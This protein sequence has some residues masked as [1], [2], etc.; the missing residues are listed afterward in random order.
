MTAFM[1]A[2]AALATMLLA[3]VLAAFGACWVAP[4]PAFADG[5]GEVALGIVVKGAQE[6]TAQGGSVE[7]AVKLAAKDAPVAV[8][9]AVDLL[10][11][12]KARPVHRISFVGYYCDEEGNVVLNDDGSQKKET[13]EVQDVVEGGRVSV[14]TNLARTDERGTEYWV[15]GWYSYDALGKPYQIDV[16]TY[17][18]AAGATIFCYWKQGYAVKLDPNNGQ[19]ASTGAA[20]F[21]GTVEKAYVSVERDLAF[22]QE[23]PMGDPDGFT[24]PAFPAATRAGYVFKGWYWADPSGVHDHHGRAE[25]DEATGVVADADDAKGYDFFRE[26]CADAVPT[27]Y[28]KWE[29]APLVKVQLEEARGAQ[30]DEWIDL[31]FWPGRGYSLQRPVADKEIEPG[32]VIGRDDVPEEG[33]DVT[34]GLNIAYNPAPRYSTQVFSGWGYEVQ[35]DAGALVPIELV[36][37]HKAEGQDGFTYTLGPLAF[38]YVNSKLQWTGPAADDNDPSAPAGQKVATWTPLFDFAHIS[39]TAPFEVVFQ[40]KGD[41]WATDATDVDAYTADELDRKSGW[42]WVESI[43]QSFYN[44]SSA[45]EGEES[46][47]VSVY[48]SGIECVDTGAGSLIPSADGA[49]DKRVFSLYDTP[50]LGGGTGGNA[51]LGAASAKAVSFGYATDRDANK[52]IVGANDPASW[53][54]L[55]PAG[56]DDAAEVLY[57]GLDLTKVRLNRSAIALGS[58]PGSDSDAASSYKA[59]LANVKYT[60]SVVP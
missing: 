28:A 27:L 57:F 25:L 13:I 10:V 7:L 44:R 30:Q 41:A 42:T 43:E 11:N 6:Q 32:F 56:N 20:V 29:V 38:D 31:W 35:G 22:E 33:L 18:A 46:V 21:D 26:H 52:V 34:A 24:P 4:T 45:G 48:V 51:S 5:G 19:D 40:K 54:V 50:L 1:K 15:D 60:Y 39:V 12:V 37:A 3:V 8:E 14:P 9:G 2:Q 17:E 23:H 55:D 49:S 53:I 59:P 47:P 36:S 58:P 16:E